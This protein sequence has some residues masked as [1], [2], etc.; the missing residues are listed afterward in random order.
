MTNLPITTSTPQALPSGKPAANANEGDSS[1]QPFGEVLARQINGPA[2]RI[3]KPD[4]KL[5]I[6]LAAQSV[7]GTNDLKADDKA[8]PDATATAATPA[9]MLTALLPQMMTPPPVA[10]SGA[11]APA[12]PGRDG[13]ADVTATLQGNGRSGKLA[14]QAETATPLQKPDAVKGDLPAAAAPRNEAATPFSAALGELAARASLKPEALSRDSAAVPA[15]PAPQSAAAAVNLA[16][17]TAPVAP[18]V[19]A[20][21]MKVETPVSQPR[22]G[23]EFGQKIVWL[24]TSG[25]DQ[26]AELHLNPPQLGPL[27]VVIKVSGDQATALFTSP[28]AAVREAVEQAIPKLRDMMA[29]NGIML[30]NATVSDQ[31]QRDQGRPEASRNPTDNGDTSRDAAP[32]GTTTTAR[33][34]PIARH[35]GIV[36]TFA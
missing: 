7:E 19:Q 23:D 5:A 13:K 3:A 1:A 33:V 14:V 34:S 30:G 24:A 32:A 25:T 36:D 18:L 26:T 31:A 8:L 10:T 35:N 6:E 17:N 4:D 27:D 29:D 28:H 11:A 2:Q 9:D 21:Q 20:A 16:Q 12:E 15:A 22:W